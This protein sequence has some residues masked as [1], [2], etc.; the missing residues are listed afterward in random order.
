MPAS[1]QKKISPVLY[2][3]FGMIATGKSTLAGEWARYKELSSYNSDWVRKELAGINPSE[4]RRQTIDAGIYSREF[5][6]KTYEELREKAE[7]L[8]QRGDSVV[9]DASYQY[10]RDRQ[11][12]RDLAKKLKCQVCFIL[13]HC[14]EEEMKRRMEARAQDPATVSDGRWDIYLKQKE[15]FEPPDELGASELIS[16]D[17]QAPL[18]ELLEK[19]AG[20]LP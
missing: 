1:E 20:K 18:K 10:A 4:S 11:D 17:T 5:S 15:R 6:R 19:L 16:I 12:I 9:L 14:P 2:V 8:L 3:F 7:A 13:C